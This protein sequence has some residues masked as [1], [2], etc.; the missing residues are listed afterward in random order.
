MFR[1]YGGGDTEGK[2]IKVVK[3]L[4]ELPKTGFPKSSAGESMLSAVFLKV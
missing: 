1:K 2:D 4:W 3:A